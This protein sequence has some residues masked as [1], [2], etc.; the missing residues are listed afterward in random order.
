MGF[1]AINVIEGVANEDWGQVTSSAASLALTGI[2][3][4]SPLLGIGIGA[5]Q[6]GINGAVYLYQLSWNEDL[7]TG[8]ANAVMHAKGAL[9]AANASINDLDAQS[10]ELGCP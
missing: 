5:A 2:G 3:R 1:D 10:K 6:N 7:K 9:R 8:F 4:T